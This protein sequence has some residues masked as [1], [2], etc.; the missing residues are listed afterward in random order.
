MAITIT[1]LTDGTVGGTGVF[2]VLM[3]VATKHLDNQYRLGR[4]SK[5]DYAEVY[6]QSLNHTMTQAMQFVIQS[7]STNAQ[8]AIQEAELVN[9]PK[10]G[11]LLDQEL[12]K[13]AAEIAVLELKDEEL[14]A[15]IQLIEVQKLKVEQEGILVPKQGLIMDQELLNMEQQ[16]LKS[17]AEVSIA[18]Q[19]ATLIPKKGLLMDEQVAKAAAEKTLIDN[20]SETE[21]AQINDNQ[22]DGS[23]VGGVVGKQKSLYTNQAE[24]YLRDAEQKLLSEILK[25]YLAQISTDTVGTVPS[26]TTGTK[27]DEV[28][29][30]ARIGAGIP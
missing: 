3:D 7:A 14:A 21:F 8:V 22:T 13:G 19:E 17:I 18:Q 25:V 24:G 26:L 2:D 9:V 16:V 15:Q 6:I 20:K 27:I 30:K 10:K 23:T 5:S 28:I 12:L 29:D 1:D 11:L 4:I